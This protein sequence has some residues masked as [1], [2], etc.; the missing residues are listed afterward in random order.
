MKPLVIASANGNRCL[1]ENQTID[2]RLA[3]RRFLAA[4]QIL[5]STNGRLVSPRAGGILL[6]ATRSL[7]L[8]P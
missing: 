4:V 8:P 7:P 5:N 3:I 2:Y 6:R 1:A